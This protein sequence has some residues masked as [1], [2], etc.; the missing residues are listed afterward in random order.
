MWEI[1][2]ETATDTIQIVYASDLFELMAK[3]PETIYCK[4]ID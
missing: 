3:Y 4:Q 2:T 1:I